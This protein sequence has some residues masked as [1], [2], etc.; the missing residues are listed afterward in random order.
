MKKILISMLVIMLTLCS[1]IGITTVAFADEGVTVITTKDEFLALNGKTG[2]YELGAD[3]DLGS[4]YVG[5]F[6]GT[7]DGKGHVIDVNNRAGVFGTLGSTSS[8]AHVKDFHVTGKVEG[9]GVVGGV[10]SIALGTIEG[11]TVKAD[12][13]STGNHMVAGFANCS[14]KNSL[15]IKNCIFEGSVSYKQGFKS[16]NNYSYWGMFLGYNGGAFG[17]GAVVNSIA[18][19]TYEIP[20]AEVDTISEIQF[21][22]VN[23]DAQNT[24]TSKWEA[25]P[26]GD[27]TV[28]TF[29]CVVNM[30]P[31]TIASVNDEGIMAN[32]GTPVIRFVLDDGSYRYLDG[33]DKANACLKTH[34]GEGSLA[35]M[36][37]YKDISYLPIEKISESKVEENVD[38][39][40][41]EVTSTYSRV[42]I[43]T[44]EEFESFARI[45]NSAVPAEFTNKDG[46][47]ETLSILNTLATSIKL[48][49]D[50]VLDGDDNHNPSEFYGIG[51]HEFFPYRG[52]IDGNGHSIS[53]NINAPN[54]YCIG[55]ISVA[56]EISEDIIVKDL[57]V[58][59]SI[60]G[61]TKVGIV[62]YF[63]MVCNA[64]VEGGNAKFE[65]VVNNASV[66]G[67]VAVGGLLGAVSSGQDT[68][69]VFVDNCVNNGDIT[70]TENGAFGGGIVGCAGLY[71]T[72]GVRVEN[73]T[74]NGDVTALAG[75][76]YVGGI[77]GYISGGQDAIP[78]PSAIINCYGNGDV[79][80]DSGKVAG[81]VAGYAIAL[82]SDAPAGS[83]GEYKTTSLA[84]LEKIDFKTKTMSSV[85]GNIYTIRLT[86]EA[87]AN[88]NVNL[89]FTDSE[90]NRVVHEKSDGTTSEEKESNI[91]GEYKVRLEPGVY[92][93]TIVIRNNESYYGAGAVGAEG[94]TRNT[95]ATY[96]VTKKALSY[97]FTDVVAA[98]T[99][100]SIS[101]FAA[102]EGVEGYDKSAHALPDTSTLTGAR[103]SIEYYKDGA[104]VDGVPSEA[105]EYT[106]KISLSATDTFKSR[107]DFADTVYEVKMT[108]S[109][110]ITV[111][112]KNL[113]ITKGQTPKFEVTVQTYDGTTFTD[114]ES[115]KLNYSIAGGLP[116][117]DLDYGTYVINVTGED[118]IGGYD[119]EYKSGTLVVKKAE[120]PAPTPTPGTS[121]K[122]QSFGCGL[123]LGASIGLG[124]ALLAG[125][126]VAIRRKRS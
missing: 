106:V 52:G 72:T 4:D 96:T 79:T 82:V 97:E 89:I 42:T 43:S 21:F 125:A 90:G 28:Y 119:V 47:K 17:G 14:G 49:D 36:Y 107:Y 126:F 74:N 39:N 11:V 33:F 67:N 65:E 37:K 7:L 8:P 19:Y 10:A 6:Y 86:A 63:D 41:T 31:V 29:D 64:Y 45:I 5:S 44:E 120:T 62:G 34:F 58:N 50:I 84:N 15:T 94:L 110:R 108:I 103:W 105:G 59:G 124:I 95:S 3:I 27:N 18:R 13:S 78:E 54:G 22:N 1:A 83:I 23:N 115:L 32:Y 87:T 53:L 30:Q 80:A 123:D 46:E 24:V 101:Y 2:N 51:K 92:T 117:D 114:I 61:K 12:V 55:L 68:V 85:Y 93:V 40:K 111:T 16:T 9:T 112:V 104:K 20:T 70:V 25:V 75:A 26:S 98:Y 71:Q 100:D 57:T 122:T 60:I 88:Y 99:G 73:S 38:G 81:S 116:V 77:A 76:N 109:G 66:T 91:S 35:T 113:E 118:K 56:S 121:D 48:G 69:K 102:L